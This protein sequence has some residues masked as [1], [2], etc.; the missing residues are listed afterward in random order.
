MIRLLIASAFVASTVGLGERA[1][2]ADEN[3]LFIPF[4]SQNCVRFLQGYKDED[5]KRVRA[6]HPAGGYYDIAYG[7]SII[8]ISGY[9]T[10]FTAAFIGVVNVF[11]G[12][13]ISTVS[14]LVKRECDRNPK[15]TLVEAV[16]TVIMNNRK[17]WQLSV[18]NSK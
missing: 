17:N 9:I 2:A 10:G 6:I 1:I 14:E 13:E 5:A 12:V 15:S 4:G 3:G 11:P 18:S 16:N 7:A 8:F